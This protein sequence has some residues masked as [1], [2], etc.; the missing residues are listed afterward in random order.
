MLF[1]SQ[2]QDKVSLSLTPTVPS[3]QMPQGSVPF[4]HKP[5]FMLLRCQPKTEAV[6]SA[7]NYCPP[8]TVGPEPV[9]SPLLAW[10]QLRTMQ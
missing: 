7:S 2:V 4:T 5:D 3:G 1:G 8:Q 6:V 10:G 9:T